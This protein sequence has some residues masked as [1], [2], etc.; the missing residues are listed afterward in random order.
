MGITLMPGLHSGR[1]YEGRASI[2][3]VKPGTVGRIIFELSHD[4]TGKVKKTPMPS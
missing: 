2:E 3:G 4:L 1:E